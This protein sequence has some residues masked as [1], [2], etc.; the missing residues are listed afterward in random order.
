MEIL[1]TRKA[2]IESISFDKI[3]CKDS[4]EGSYKEKWTC[5]LKL[6]FV[7]KERNDIKEFI[8]NEYRA[9]D[10]ISRNI[11]MGHVESSAT[12][13]KQNGEQILC[14]SNQSTY[15]VYPRHPETHEQTQI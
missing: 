9:Y 4:A 10:D 14:F 3:T 5:I 2:M 8:I 12:L 1:S 6:R 15:L 7:E 13:I 11:I